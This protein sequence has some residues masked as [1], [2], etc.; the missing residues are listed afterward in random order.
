VEK[1]RDRIVVG[2][3][4]PARK[5]AAPAAAPAAKAKGVAQR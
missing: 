4:A 5:A 2:A 1:N 3:A